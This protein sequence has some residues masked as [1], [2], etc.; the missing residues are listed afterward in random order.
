MLTRV[1]IT[2]NSS[3]RQRHDKRKANRGSAPSGTIVWVTL[4]GKDLRLA[5]VWPRVKEIQN[6]WNWREMN[7][8][9]WNLL[10]SH[11]LQLSLLTTLY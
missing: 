10:L 5:Q 6:R 8:W 1:V 9:S 2:G 7:I 11:R 4:P 3:I